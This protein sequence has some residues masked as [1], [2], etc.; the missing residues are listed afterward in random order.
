[1]PDTKKPRSPVEA[2]ER[3]NALQVMGRLSERPIVG[4]IIIQIEIS[5]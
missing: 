2:E 3:G 1:M 5:G 4:T